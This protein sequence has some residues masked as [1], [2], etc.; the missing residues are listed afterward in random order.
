MGKAAGEYAGQETAAADEGWLDEDL[1]DDLSMDLQMAFNLEDD[2]YFDGDM[3]DG[4]DAEP[5]AGK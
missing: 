1:D 5:P 3:D 4:Q 2:L